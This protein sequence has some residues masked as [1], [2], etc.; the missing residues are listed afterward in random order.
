MRRRPTHLVRLP[1][2]ECPASRHLVMGVV[3]LHRVR[4]LQ[5]ES[6]GE[7]CP[8]TRHPL[9]VP[10]PIVRR[11]PTHSVREL[12]HWLLR[13]SKQGQT[14]TLSRRPLASKVAAVVK[15]QGRGSSSTEVQPLSWRRQAC[16]SQMVRVQ[17]VVV[18]ETL[19]QLLQKVVRGDH[20]LRPVAGDRG[21]NAKSVRV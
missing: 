16:W 5:M 1:D 10:D 15:E 12:V 17:V 18:Q 11:H 8:V 3:L 20:L 14:S 9:R 4:L 7:E 2:A 13:K 6:M 19:L 21:L